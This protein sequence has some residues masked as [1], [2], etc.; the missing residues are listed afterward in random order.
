MGLATWQKAIIVLATLFFAYVGFDGTKEYGI[1]WQLFGM[2]IGGLTGA[3]GGFMV[4]AHIF[5]GS[6]EED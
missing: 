3:I 4:I 6:S 1:F 5:G 2:V